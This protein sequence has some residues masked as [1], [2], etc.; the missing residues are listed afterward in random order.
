MCIAINAVL[1]LIV[2]RRSLYKE[3]S[4][5]NVGH[6]VLSSILENAVFL[7]VFVAAL[8]SVGS[9]AFDGGGNGEG[10]GGGGS[11]SSSSG[12]IDD[13]DDDR[14]QRV[15]RKF[16]TRVYLAMQFP[17]LFKVG[18][19]AMQIFDTEPNLLFLF[20]LVVLSVQSLSFRT[21][22]NMSSNNVSVCMTVAVLCRLV[23]RYGFYTI[24]QQ[25]LIGLVL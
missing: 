18:V 14:Q 15:I 3:F 25:M 11:S 24:P 6:A 12:G 17:E 16:D 13:D 2:L 7:L 1:K 4:V 8:R 9:S 5:F 19:I 23:V 22:T 20:G 10:G 21:V